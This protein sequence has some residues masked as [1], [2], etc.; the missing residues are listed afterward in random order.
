[1]HPG[2]DPS[3]SSSNEKRQALTGERSGLY[4]YVQTSC[5]KILITK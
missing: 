3:I 2:A 5:I 1:M 4:L